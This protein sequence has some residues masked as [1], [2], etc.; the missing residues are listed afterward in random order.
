MVAEDLDEETIE[1]RV[2]WAKTT[3]IT[4]EELEQRQ[5]F[6]KALLAEKMDNKSEELETKLDEKRKRLHQLRDELNQIENEV[7]D[8]DTISQELSE[9]RWKAAEESTEVQRI[10]TE[11]EAE[12]AAFE[13]HAEAYMEL[14]EMSR[15]E[16]K[17]LLEPLEAV[18][19][20][21]VGD[22]KATLK[23]AVT[24]LLNKAI[25]KA[26]GFERCVDTVYKRLKDAD[27]VY[28]SWKQDGGDTEDFETSGYPGDE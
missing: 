4:P 25:K 21:A 14:T 13:Q 2:Q 24:S 8:S 3:D 16:L 1:D 20:I 10:L 27:L 12:K 15:E 19:K 5:E 23:D 11:L 28:G 22:A 18:K 7:V 6:E 26:S 17:A 9:K